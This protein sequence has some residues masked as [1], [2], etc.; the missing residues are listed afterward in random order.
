MSSSEN[1]YNQTIQSDSQH[2][3]R[4]LFWQILRWTL[5]SLLILAGMAGAFSFWSSY[6]ESN[7]FQQENLKNIATLIINNNDMTETDEPSALTTP[8]HVHYKTD[9]EDTAP[10]SAKPCFFTTK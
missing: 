9:N 3:H 10:Q 1:A 6:H 8:N 5:V 7:N 2:Q 4:S